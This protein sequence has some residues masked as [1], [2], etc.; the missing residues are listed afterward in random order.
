MKLQLHSLSR[1][2]HYTA[3]YPDEDR[4][5]IV[6]TLTVNKSKSMDSVDHAGECIRRYVGPKSV[7]QRILLVGS[8]CK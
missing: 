5:S 4:L 8:Q 2:I 7:L 6:E 1:S 3:H